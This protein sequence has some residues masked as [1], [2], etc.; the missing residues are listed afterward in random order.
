MGAFAQFRRR[1]GGLFWALTAATMVVAFVRTHQWDQA[2]NR[3]R[4]IYQKA[5]YESSELTEGMAVNF[6]KVSVAGGPARELLLTDVIR[7]AQGVQ[8]DL[9]VLPL[10]G[11]AIAPA[12]KYINQAGD[13]CQRLLT[14]LGEGDS[15]SSEDAANLTSL[16]ETAAQLS[17]ALSAIIQEYEAGQ[18]PLTDRLIQLESLSGESAP[19]V[20]YPTLLY[21]G[22]FSDGATGSEFKA[23]AGMNEISAQE[24]EQ[25]LRNYVGADR[26]T[27]IAL[28]GESSLPTPCYG[29]SLEAGGYHLSAAVTKMGGQVLYLLCSDDVTGELLSLSQCFRAAETFLLSRGY[30][31]MELNYYS[32]HDGILTANYAATQNGVTL[33]PDLVKIQ[34]SMADGAILGVEAGNYL[35]NHVPRSLDLPALTEAEARA[36]VN[37]ALSV[38]SVRLCVIP[39]DAAEVYCYEISCSGKGGTYLVYL[40]AVTGA[41][42][43]IMQV[44]GDAQATLVM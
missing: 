24:A 43:D 35:R 16:S 18:W 40:D 13:F 1:S 38:E 21:D 39:T 42:V 31:G 41:E 17:L 5:L 7:Q 10:S 8:A 19:A 20:D 22:P 44:V 28:D 3:L 15:L 26:V 27:K 29:F 37:P 36:R 34:I 2:T 30:S 12:M 32:K 33:Y 14:R 9:A 25:L 6:N 11:S 23:L 4:G